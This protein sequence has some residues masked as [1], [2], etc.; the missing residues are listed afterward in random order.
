MATGLYFFDRRVSDIAA[1]VQPSAR[2]ELEIVDVLTDYLEREAL[3]VEVLGRGYAWLDTGTQESLIQ[4]ATYVATMEQR[5]GLK[6]SCP[7]EIALRMG[8]I[9]LKQFNSIL[10][11]LPNSGYVQYLRFISAEFA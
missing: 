1:G 6:I 10:S 2:G 5:Q 4:A 7:E 9:D 8:F 11:N 3:R